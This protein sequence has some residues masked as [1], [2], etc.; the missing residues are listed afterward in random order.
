MANNTDTDQMLHSAASD[1]GLRLLRHISLNTRGK[2]AAI[3]LKKKKKK[4]KITKYEE[5]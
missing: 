3:D 2:Y 5:E 1:L 4:K